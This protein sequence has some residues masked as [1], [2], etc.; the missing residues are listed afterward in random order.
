MPVDFRF[1]RLSIR[2]F[3][4][5]RELDIDLPEKIPLHVIGGNNS[6]K[7]TVLDALALAFR[8]GGMH[9]FIPTEFDFFHDAN[10]TPTSDFTITLSFAAQETKHLPAVQG[11]GN[12]ISVHGIRV[13]GST[14]KRG[15]HA[16]QHVLVDGAGKTITFSQR[17]ALKGDVKEDFADHSVG[18]RPV[19]ARPD[20]IREYLPEVWLLRPDNLKASLYHWKTGPLQRLSQMLAQRFLHTEWTLNVGGKNRPMPK[21]LVSA[22]GFFRE[23]VTQ[24]PFWK[25]DLKAKLQDT[26]SKYIGRDAQMDLRP[27]VRTI[28][29]WLAQQLVVAFATDSGGATTPL[30]KMGDGWQSLIRVAALDVLSQY[31]EQIRERV[32]LLFE[33]PETYLHPH[34]VRKL[35]SVLEQLAGNGW[36][37]V[38]A[39]HAPEMISFAS[40]QM[41]VRLWRRPDGVGKGELRTTDAGS[42]VTFQERLDER[43]GH[44][45]LFAQRAVLCEGKDDV[46]AIRLFLNKRGFDLDGRSVSVINV[47]D[48]GAIPTYAEMARK[49]GIPWCA[50]TDEDL[51]AEGT[52]QKPAEIARKKLDKLK[53]ELDRSLIWKGKLEKCLGKVSGKAEPMWISRQLEQKSADEIEAQYPDYASVGKEVIAWAGQRS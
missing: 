23:A 5:I 42:H 28:E 16:H 29:D 4:G 32:V 19:N 36:T 7:S 40:P 37:I 50:I 25:D 18:W 52:I 10:G 41:V 17:T 13:L 24:F 43:G 27:D 12:P 33:E 31:P 9:A 44:E 38:T 15:R 51:S 21:T 30:E 45:M 20:D 8:G 6:G 26:L 22:H 3:R 49:L 11:V 47:G 14:D 46:F 35:R 1:S 48:V 2:N 34:L 53:T 39:T